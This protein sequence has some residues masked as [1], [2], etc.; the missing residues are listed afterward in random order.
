MEHFI[1]NV[2]P[3]ILEFGNLQLRWYGVL[4]VGSFFLGLMILQWI[5]KREGKDPAVL[6][7]LLIYVMI[8]AV[9]GARL[10][11]CFFYEPE[12]YLSHPLEIL[13]VWK[14]GLASHGGLAG[15]LITLY[16]FAKR[17]NTPYMWLLS[18]VAIPGALTAAFV[19]FGNLFNSEILG[20][21]S[22]LPWAIVF[23][24]VDL[25]PRH[26]V[27]LY[28]AFAYLIILVIL[29]GIYRKVSP[30]FA[31]KILPGTFLVLVFTA[32]FFLEYTKTKQETY[33]IDLPFTTG[34]LL[35]VPYILLGIAWII[36]AL[37]SR[38]KG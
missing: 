2:N 35:S 12:Y 7:H 25:I 3:N 14:G 26:P 9:V 21:P 19:R 17:Y 32:R 24:R 31:T 30:I 8:G 28:E 33:T 38:Q 36:W 5:Y 16:I 23:K 27:Q 37:K 4:F 1:W 20:L 18:R 6:D 10:V 13:K 34:Q 15:V 11:H 29:I 22:E